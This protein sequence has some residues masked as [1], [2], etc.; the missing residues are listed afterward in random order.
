MN[1][2]CVEIENIYGMI[3]L[4]RLYENMTENKKELGGKS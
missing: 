1:K 4:Y 2:Q 3:G